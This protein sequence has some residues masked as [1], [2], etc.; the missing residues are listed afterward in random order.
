MKKVF[1]LF[2]IFCNFSFALFADAIVPS[3]KRQSRIGPNTR[4]TLDFTKMNYNM[5]T[6]IVFDMMIDPEKYKNKTVKIHGQ[7]LSDVYEGTRTFAVVIWDAGGC[8]PTGVNV[9]P[10]EGKKYPEDFP[11][12][13]SE[14]TI[15]GTLEILQLYGGDILCLVAERWE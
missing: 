11:P 8:C 7:F 5:A 13:E 2:L 9:V 14:V 1:L 15:T 4:I 3:V 6:G 10:L 12:N